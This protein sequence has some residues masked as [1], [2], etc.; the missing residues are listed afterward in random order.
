[1]P[2]QGWEEKGALKK[3]LRAQIGCNIKFEKFIQTDVAE[4]RKT[5]TFSLF[6]FFSKSKIIF[7]NIWFFFFALIFISSLAEFYIKIIF[8]FHWSVKR[9]KFSIYFF[10][11][12]LIFFV[13]YIN[14]LLISVK[15]INDY[16]YNTNCSDDRKYFLVKIQYYSLP[17]KFF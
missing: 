5:R 14:F 3:H 2:V 15:Y 13:L 4:S 11:H 6:D 9:K 17:V 16:Y 8:F 1:M 12:E 7:P 10:I